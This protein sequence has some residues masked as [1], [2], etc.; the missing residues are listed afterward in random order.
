MRSL[1]AYP[2]GA[3]ASTDFV[4]HLIEMARVQRIKVPLYQVYNLG[5]NSSKH[6]LYLT[7]KSELFYEDDSVWLRD[8]SGDAHV[9]ISLRSLNVIPNTYN[10]NFIFED[11]DLAWDY[12]LHAEVMPQVEYNIDE[13]DNWTVQ[14]FE[15]WYQYFMN[16]ENWNLRGDS[17]DDGIDI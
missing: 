11:E 8:F 3:I 1:G 2:Y 10:D 16:Y 9:A 7:E 17:D 15:E 13:L 5:D 6:T 14:I 4:A 12:L